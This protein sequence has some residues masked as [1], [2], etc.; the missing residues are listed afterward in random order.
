MI[1]DAERLR[2]VANNIEG[3]WA[4][5]LCDL[6]KDHGLIDDFKKVAHDDAEALREVAANI[7]RSKH[8]VAS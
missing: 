1:T 4:G 3:F 6:L 8:P 2:V 7:E 5:Y